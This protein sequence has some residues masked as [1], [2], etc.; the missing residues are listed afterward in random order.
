MKGF[1]RADSL[2]NQKPVVTF[3][4]IRTRIFSLVLATAT[5]LT[6][7]AAP[8]VAKKAA[9]HPEKTRTQRVDVKAVQAPVK[10]KSNKGFVMPSKRT[11]G[12]TSMHQAKTGVATMAPAKAKQAPQKVDGV[13]EMYGVVIYANSWTQENAPAGFYKIPTASDQEF[14]LD[15]LAEDV[16]YGGCNTPEFYFGFNYT[17]YG[18]F[19]LAGFATYDLASQ[20]AIASEMIDDVYDLASGLAYDPVSGDLYGVSYTADGDPALAKYAVSSDGYTKTLIAAMGDTQLS[21]LAVDKDGKL[22]GISKAGDLYTVDK[23]TAELTLVGSTGVVP[24]YLGGAVIDTKSNRMFWSVCTDSASGLYEVNTTSGAATLLTDFSDGE[25]VIGLYLPLALAED[26]APAAATDLVANFPEGNLSGTISFTAP[27][28]LYDGSAATGTVHYDVLVNGESIKSADTTYGTQENIAYT[29]PAAGEY[30]IVVIMSNSVGNGPKAKT[31]LFIGKGV[32][33]QTEVTASYDEAAGMMHI[34]WL[35][36]TESYDGGYINPAEVTYKVLDAEGN[37]LVESTTATSYEYAVAKPSTMTVFKYTVIAMYNGTES[38][39][40]VSNSVVLGDVVLPYTNDFTDG[41]GEGWT[42]SNVNGDEKTWIWDSSDGGIARV[43][44]NKSMAMDDWLFTCP[45]KLEAGKMY[46]V[47]FYAWGSTSFTERIE[48]KYGKSADVAG[49]TG[50]LLEPTEVNAK[51]DAPFVAYLVCQES[52]NYY[53]GFHG[54]SDPDMFNLKLDDFSIGAA[55]STAAPAKITDLTATAGANGAKT[56]TLNFTAPDKTIAGAATTLTKI[57]ITR[58]G[59]LVNTIDSPV[60]GTAQSY[61]DNLAASGTYNYEVIAYNA[62]GA[63]QPASVSC[64]CGIDVPVA[65]AS[66]SIVE[67]ATPGQVTVSWEAVTEDI[68]GT[69]LSADQISYI[70][71]D[72]VDGQWTPIQDTPITGTTYSFTAVEAGAQ[73]FAQVAIFAQT[74]AGAGDGIATD[75]IPVGTPYNGIEESFPDSSLNYIWGINTQGGG[76]WNI[77]GDDRFTDLTSADSDNGYLA[78]QAQYLEQFASFFSGKIDLSQLAA[79]GL[80]FYTYNIVGSDGNE[81][82]NEIVVSVKTLNGEWTPVQSATVNE[83]CNGNPGWNKVIIPLNAYAGQVIQFQLTVTCKGFAVALFDAL[84]V[85]NLLAHDLKA[86]DVT[87]PATVDAGSDYT[88]GLTVQNEGGMA[89]E[90]FTVEVKANGEVVESIKGENLAAY[91]SKTYEIQQSFSPLATEPV[92]YE[93]SII[94]EADEDTSNNKF[95]AF[96]VTPKESSLP[97]VSDLKAE[98]TEA[99]VK[100]TWSEPDLSSAPGQPVT[101]DFED[102]ETGS[103]EYDGWTMV[104]KD[105]YTLGG[106]QGT[107]VPGVTIGETTGSF[108]IFDSSLEQFNQTFTAHS[109]VKYLA[110]LFGYQG[111]M[112]ANDWAITPELQG[113]AQTVSVY[114]RSYSSQYPEAMALYYS[115]GSLNP[116]DFIEVL[117]VASVPQ[118]WTEYKADLPAGAKYFAI[119]SKGYDAF[120]LMVDD[121]TFIPAGGPAGDV[122]IVGYNVYRDGVLITETPVAETSYV[123][124]NATEGTHKYVVTVVY[125]KG[126]SGAS[127]EVSVEVSGIASLKAGARVKTAHNTIIISNVA[128]AAVAVMSADGKVVYNGK[129]DAKVSVIAGVYVVKVGN[130]VVKV[131]VR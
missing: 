78:F 70:V 95:D 1:R 10:A 64:F 17:N 32:P 114:A 104:D 117:N 74:E 24:N 37:V 26:G 125:D 63:G 110:S 27:T 61:T 71:C 129:G 108:F 101:V 59:E 20:E 128:D 15:F 68:H 9:A 39:P 88:I 96:T 13:P 77:F 72:Y 111:G 6:M 102:G 83:M 97:K 30:S 69:T 126:Q 67:D 76:S 116:D 14:S 31:S 92:D 103:F 43:S 130:K 25:E 57:E 66:A 5:T 46:P 35:P 89:A 131:Q 109:G 50:V 105:E 123:D 4:N 21:D 107:D 100:L 36:V 52:G 47:S 58:D 94:F 90:S 48:V 119:Q 87:A 124:A 86:G 38:S 115:T 34:S 41:L 75:M 42:V 51:P 53:I 22:Y 65:P 121:V 7:S 44:Y 79:P 127:N 18:F 120:M 19:A 84:K 98:S 82:L 33:A 122:N 3:M 55:M 28:T 45:I 118:D 12:Q 80:T 73:D 99:G 113:I 91:A 85:G 62:D 49:M 2:Y 54:I 8:Q 56:I 81:D 93:A 106:F 60:A 40:A 29:A 112:T 11:V 16:S 23:A